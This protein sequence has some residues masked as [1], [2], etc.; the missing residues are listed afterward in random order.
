MERS[1]GEELK[2]EHNRELVNEYEEADEE[3]YEFTEEDEALMRPDPDEAY[4]LY[5]D[6]W[7]ESL[8]CD[9]RKL[10]VEYVR[11]KHGYYFGAD[12]RFVE[13]A[14]LCL[15]DVSGCQ[16]LPELNGRVGAKM[17][18]APR[19]EF[20]ESFDELKTPKEVVKDE[21]QVKTKS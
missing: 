13:H 7:S 17:F 20:V 3:L 15:A 1:M 9:I 6:A 2:E 5:R 18:R 8:L 12:E 19:V 14:I 21:V 10:F 16:L 4:E 11:D